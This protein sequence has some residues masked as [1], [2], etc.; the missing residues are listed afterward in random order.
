[1]YNTLKV[2]EIQKNLLHRQMQ[3]KRELAR[4]KIINEEFKILFADILEREINNRKEK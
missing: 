4:K 2:Y 3:P 1:M